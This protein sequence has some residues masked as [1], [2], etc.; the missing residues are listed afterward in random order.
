M[1]DLTK[2]GYL[3]MSR[4]E[5]L[6]YRG[7]F[8]HRLAE[9]RSISGLTWRQMSEA[10]GRPLSQYAKME[11]N[12]GRMTPSVA[13]ALSTFFR[14]GINDFLGMPTQDEL[15]PFNER[16]IDVMALDWMVD[17]EYSDLSTQ[18]KASYNFPCR[19]FI[20]IRN[21]LGLSRAKLGDYL[22]VSKQA[23]RNW[24]GM[25]S[26]PLMTQCF[27][28]ASV[29]GISVN[30]LLG[31]P[32]DE[33]LLRGSSS[34]RAGE[35]DAEAANNLVGKWADILNEHIVCE[36]DRRIEEVLEAGGKTIPH[37]EDVFRPFKLT[38][39]ENVKAVFLCTGAVESS[40]APDG[41][42]LSARNI[43]AEKLQKQKGL[44]SYRHTAELESLYSAYVSGLG[45]PEPH[46]NDLAPWAKQ[47]VLLLNFQCVR[48]FDESG[49]VVGLPQN[50]TGALVKSSIRHLS[51]Q[52]QPVVFVSFATRLE[53]ITH[54][55]ESFEGRDH[56]YIDLSAFRK[57]GLPTDFFQR[58]N[59]LLIEMGAEPI[60]WRL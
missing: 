19:N 56:R 26:L 14:V 42:A 3:H 32:E 41:L 21:A 30:C 23:W 10:I 52:N 6:N 58:I 1:A 11:R 15:E 9:L 59:E 55:A 46:T 54:S 38:P 48:L 7:Y 25:G 51:C 35:S 20:T 45:F 27:Y 60:D 28:V 5:R 16:A 34:N 57:G 22:G 12:E 36:L 44:L 33:M 31:L 43:A 39:P 18:E 50:L 4:A 37:R 8:N 17:E 29:F 13:F 53:R 49:E 24:E 40:K 2:E 47:G